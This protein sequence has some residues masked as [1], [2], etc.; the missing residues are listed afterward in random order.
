[1]EWTVVKK[2]STPDFDIE[3]GAAKIGEDILLYIQGGDKPHIGCTVMAVPRPSLFGNG[4]RSVT[5]SVLNLTGHKDESI[6]RSLAEKVC[7]ATGKTV[8]C[9]G[10]F[11]LENITTQQIKKV[12]LAGKRLEELLIKEL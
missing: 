9:T 5:S 12:E 4:E 1:M 3:A 7:Q 8:V 11:H 10:G 6:C 2:I